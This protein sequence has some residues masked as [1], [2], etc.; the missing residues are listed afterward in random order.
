[1]IATDI[2]QRLH[3]SH[4]EINQI[5]EI[6]GNAGM[7]IGVMHGGFVIHQAHLGYQDVAQRV[8]PN[9]KT[10]YEI[11]SLTKAII[12]LCLSLLVESGDLDWDTSLRELLPDYV[13]RNKISKLPHDEVNLVDVLAHRH[14][15]TQRNMYRMQGHA[16]VLMDVE[17]TLNVFSDLEPIKEFRSTMTYNNWGYGVAGSILEN[18][19][20]MSVGE[21]ALKNIFDPLGMSRTTLSDPCDNNCAR[22]YV[23]LTNGTPFEV[24]RPPFSD[25]KLLAST[26]AY[27]STLDDLMTLYGFMMKSSWEQQH[28][29]PVTLNSTMPNM[30]GLWKSHIAIDENSGYGLGWVVTNL[31]VSCGLIGI[32]L[33]MVDVMPTVAKGISPTHLIYHQGSGVGALS[34]VYLLPESQSV[35]VVLSNSLDLCDSSDWVAQ[36]LLEFLVNSPEHNDYVHWAKVASNNSINQMPQMH[37]RL[38]TEQILGTKPKPLQKYVGRYWNKLHNFR[39]DVSIHECRLR[40]TVQGFEQVHYDL[41]H[42]HYDCFMA[43]FAMA[44]IGFHKFN[45]NANDVDVIESVN[46][47]YDKN[48][49][50]GE[51]FHRSEKVLTSPKL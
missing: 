23:S 12:S 29:T 7:S 21:F 4:T 3:A 37:E 13:P 49:P 39:L 14:G 19:S 22:T 18:I 30:A 20:G 45:F 8:P 11:A 44:V 5:R 35:V 34:A 15:L 50:G 46:W 16:T 36:M 27:K 17:E 43:F 6:S 40:V 48:V 26:S 32:N 38:R 1:M 25:G 10:V 41:D 51:V 2:V 31:P 28:E 47:A 42:Y 9:S 24:P 33:N